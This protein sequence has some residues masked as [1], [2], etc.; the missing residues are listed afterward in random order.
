MVVPVTATGV[1]TIVGTR[2][3]V[4]LV[5]AT[6]RLGKGHSWDPS[7]NKP[8]SNSLKKLIDKVPSEFKVNGKFDK[9]ADALEKLLIQNG[10]D[11]KR[12]TYAVRLEYT[13]IKLVS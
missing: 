7:L 10:V 5:L 11:Y 1:A 9:F 6:E 2:G 12:L 13:Q 8:I 3:R 4:A